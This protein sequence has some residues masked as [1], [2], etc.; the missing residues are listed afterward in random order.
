[1]QETDYLVFAK[2]LEETKSYE[3]SLTKIVIEKIQPMLLLIY[4]SKFA[5]DMGIG[6]EIQYV[7]FYAIQMLFGVC[8]IFLTLSGLKRGPQEAGLICIL[9][10]VSYF[11]GFGRYL[12]SPG[13]TTVVASC[14]GVAVGY[15][16]I[17][18]FIRGQMLIAS[19]LAALMVYLHQTY[20]LI[21]LLAFHTYIFY[22]FMT[23][24]NLTKKRFFQIY[25]YTGIILIPW[26]IVFA[27]NLGRL[28]GVGTDSLWWQF[29]KAKTSNPFPL[30]DG[31]IVVLPSLV[32]FSMVFWLLK[33]INA[34]MPDSS[35]TRARWVMGTV[36]VA[37]VIQIVFTEIWANGFIA[38]LGLTRM[39][40]YGVLFMVIVYVDFIWMHK[41]SDSSGLWLFFLILPVIFYRTKSGLFPPIGFFWVDLYK[42]PETVIILI[43][44]ILYIRKCGFI[45][46]QMRRQNIFSISSKLLILSVAVFLLFFCSLL[47]YRVY[48]KGTDLPTAINK[49]MYYR[50]YFWGIQHLIAISLL[51][52]IFRGL[53]IKD[54]K[55]E[56]WLNRIKTKP[57]FVV[58]LIGMIALYWP[59]SHIASSEHVKD[60]NIQHMLEFVDQNTDKNAMILIVP[61]T[62]T[63]E[64]TV[65]PMRPEFLN[66]AEV[67]FVLY[68]P[69]LRREVIKRLQLIGQ[70]VEKTYPII[71]TECRGWRQYVK[72]RCRRKTFENSVMNYNDDWRINIDKLREVA[73]NLSYVLLQNKFLCKEDKP[74]YRSG[75]LSLI[76][77]N[78]V[79]RRKDCEKA[80]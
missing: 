32:I 5:K 16:A 18:F 77:M 19:V 33:L 47:F 45:P 1:M 48:S 7:F 3:N 51:L 25:F 57:S 24:D 55:K 36:I 9:F 54:R 17:G 8:G 4:V 61:I 35:F 15:I 75:G 72:S 79:C 40:P 76:S 64:I 46:L 2:V 37:W 62:D 56:Y 44:L 63:R 10:F 59:V 27:N 42:Y 74:V 71:E 31:I 38:R 14:L 65:M 58:L 78:N 60:E 80:E 6:L 28:L 41:Q 52:W 22:D 68:V 12:S 50:D 23:D 34:Q 70:D 20:A 69:E 26:M 49:A 66:W 53:R 30:Q 39:T 67:Q 29:M 13:I 11:S 21:F 73:P 43:L